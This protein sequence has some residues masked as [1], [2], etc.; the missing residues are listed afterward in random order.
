MFVNVA[1][2]VVGAAGTLPTAKAMNRPFIDVLFKNRCERGFVPVD[3]DNASTDENDRPVPGRPSTVRP[4][5]QCDRPPPSC[6]IR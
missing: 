1:G 3:M 5:L 6:R 2:T 4:V